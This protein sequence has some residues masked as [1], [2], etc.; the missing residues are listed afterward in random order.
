MLKHATNHIQHIVRNT[1]NLRKILYLVLFVASYGFAQNGFKEIEIKD[2]IR[3]KPIKFE[4]NVQIGDSQFRNFDS[5][6]GVG[7][8]STKLKMISKY[9][10]KTYHLDDDFIND[11]IFEKATEL[12]TSVVN[13]NY[14]NFFEFSKK[15]LPND[16]VRDYDFF[17]SQEYLVAKSINLG[18]ITNDINQIHEMANSYSVLMVYLRIR[19]DNELPNVAN[20]ATEIITLLKQTYFD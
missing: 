12:S 20:D 18:L 6:T 5:K 4:Y 7:Q 16:N 17:E 13:H 1:Q 8:D 11:R 2:S 3:I 19:T 9:D 15:L 14:H 10:A